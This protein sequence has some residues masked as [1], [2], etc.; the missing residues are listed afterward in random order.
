V[1]RERDDRRLAGQLLVGLPADGVVE[2]VDRLL[3]VQAQD[4]RAARLAI[5]ARTT[6]LTVADVDREL[7]ERRLLVAW[8]NRGTLHLVRPQDYWW[9]QRI[10][11]PQLATGNARRLAQEGVSPAQADR[12]VAAVENAIAENGPMTRA[13]LREIVAAADVPVAG[14]ALVHILFRS[15]LSGR[16]VR[17]PMI[18]TQQAFVL[19]RDWLGAP[20]EATGRDTDLALLARRYLA[21]HGPAGDRDLAKWAGITLADARGGFRAAWADLEE[22]PGGLV[23]LAGRP[24]PN[25]PRRPRLLGGFDPLLHGWVDREPVLGDNQTIVTTN[26]IFRPFALVNGRAV[27]TWSMPGGRVDLQPLG[28]I[29]TPIQTELDRDARDVERFMLKSP[30]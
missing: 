6:G 19:V 16:T 20:P 15:A 5:R 13:E 12:G 11:T 23:D 2:V 26:G 9:L 30:H 22:R 18:G 1:D 28:K 8:L 24:S 21:G 4:L 10:T 14:Q 7:N 27:A 3:A 29:S 25:G 17:G